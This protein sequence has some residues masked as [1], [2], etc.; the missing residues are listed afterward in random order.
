[1][2]FSRLADRWPIHVIITDAIISSTILY[3][4]HYGNTVIVPNPESENAA[5]TPLLPFLPDYS[6]TSFRCLLVSEAAS[7]TEAL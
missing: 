3:M 7:I 4:T 5:V 6:T 2:I 1:M